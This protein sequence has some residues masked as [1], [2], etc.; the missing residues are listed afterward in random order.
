MLKNLKKLGFTGENVSY[1]GICGIVKHNLEYLAIENPKS[2]SKYTMKLMATHLVN[3]RTL[4]Y[5]NL[6][7]ST[8]FTKNVT[9]LTVAVRKFVFL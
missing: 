3:L 9:F 1:S 6:R 2:L 4:R 5:E 7:F 8:L